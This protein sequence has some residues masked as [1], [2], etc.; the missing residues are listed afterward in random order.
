M[1]DKAWKAT[2]RRMARDVGVESLLDSLLNA[3]LRVEM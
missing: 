2:E 1:P 3:L